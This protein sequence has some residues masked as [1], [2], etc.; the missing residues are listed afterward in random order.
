MRA[1]VDPKSCVGHGQCAVNA[2]DVF[3]LDD[4]GNAISPAGDIP[5]QFVDQ[6]RVGAAACPERAITL[7]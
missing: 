5:A 2:P 4:F 3:E 7:H 1:H 6:A